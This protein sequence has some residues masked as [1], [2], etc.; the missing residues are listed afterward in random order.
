MDMAWSAIDVLRTDGSADEA[1][2]R[3]ERDRFARFVVED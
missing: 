1:R 2:W 3:A